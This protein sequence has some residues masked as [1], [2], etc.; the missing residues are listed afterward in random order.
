MTVGFQF[1]LLPRKWGGSVYVIC[2][3]VKCIHE[4]TVHRDLQY[5]RNYRFVQRTE[6]G[7]VR[8]NSVCIFIGDTL[9]YIQPPAHALI[10]PILC[11]GLA[12]GT[13]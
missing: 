2:G 12:A 3:N 8:L 10:L 1:R 4:R 7:I 13:P 9:T 5:M 11:K 6:D